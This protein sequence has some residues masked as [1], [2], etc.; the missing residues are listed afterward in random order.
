MK[1]FLC[2]V[3]GAVLLALGIAKVAGLLYF[4]WIGRAITSSFGVKQGVYAMGF[5]V[6]GVALLLAGR[7]V[8]ERRGEDAV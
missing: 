8:R 5:I 3:A 1:R 2:I 7:G 4:L 6:A